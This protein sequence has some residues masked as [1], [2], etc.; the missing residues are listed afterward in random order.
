[1]SGRFKEVTIGNETYQLPLPGAS[2]PWGEEFSDLIDALVNGLQIVQGPQDIQE[3]SATILNT[4]GAKNITGLAFNTSTIRSVEISYNLSREITKT[5][6]T[7][8]TGT[9]VIQ[10]TTSDKHDL[11]T[12]DILTID[13]SNSTPSINGTYTITRVD[14]NNFTIDIGAVQVTIAGTTGTFLVQLIESGTII[15][16]YGIQGWSFTQFGDNIGSA[17][18]VFDIGSSGQATYN[19]A[20]L[21]GTGH[22]GLVKFIA[23]A[24]LDT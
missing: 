24:L 10:I 11:F 18:V 4:S 7:I 19:P 2:A 15:A 8:P 12:G 9:G 17:K 23:K 6:S 20:V 5:I 16:N 22:V 14:D 21:E 3:T 1:M 13:G